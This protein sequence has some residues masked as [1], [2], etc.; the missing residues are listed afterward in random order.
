MRIGNSLSKYNARRKRE[1][2]AAKLKRLS[3]EQ[4][5]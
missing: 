1:K 3:L 2:E 4:A 5:W